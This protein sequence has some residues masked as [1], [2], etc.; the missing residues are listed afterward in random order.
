MSRSHSREKFL[1]ALIIYIAKPHVRCLPLAWSNEGTSLSISSIYDR[2]LR[3]QRENERDDGPAAIDRTDDPEDGK[4]AESK[5][6][7]RRVVC[8]EVSTSMAL[9][10]KS[11]AHSR[12][13]ADVDA[14]PSPRT[15]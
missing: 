2:P 7:P 5:S 3:T 15:V 6:K 4:T 13:T 12:H 10:P 9:H 1:F 8:S 14:T 11:S